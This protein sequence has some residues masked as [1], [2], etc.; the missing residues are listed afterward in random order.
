MRQV[1]SILLLL[2]LL[3]PCS[4]YAEEL[5]TGMPRAS[6]IAQWGEPVYALINA[7]VWSR[8][9]Q[10]LVASFTYSEQQGDELLADYILLDAERRYISGTIPA[11]D[12]LFRVYDMISGMPASEIPYMFD[13]GSGFFINTRI[14]ADGY[15]VRWQDDCPSILLNMYL[16]V[17][18]CVLQETTGGHV[19]EYLLYLMQTQPSE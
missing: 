11:E 14:T 8:D 4:A 1:V 3:S 17:Y 15:I 13:S 9:G 7:G 2:V 19:T 5:Q 12:T 16:E 6:L 10:T 18:D